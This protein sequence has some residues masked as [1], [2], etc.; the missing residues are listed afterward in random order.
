MAENQNPET[1]PIVT[2]VEAPEPWKRVV[3]VEITRD[4]FEK[5]YTSRLKK[6][7]KGH[8][9]TFAG[10]AKADEAYHG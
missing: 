10:P 2:T 3:K 5:E 1:K 9:K 7:A 8:K 6:A 4:H